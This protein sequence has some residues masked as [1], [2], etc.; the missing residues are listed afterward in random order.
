MNTEQLLSRTYKE[1]D[2]RTWTT[3]AVTSDGTVVIG[4]GATCDQAIS[5]ATR[6]LST[7]ESFLFKPPQEQLQKLLS[8]TKRGQLGSLAAERCIRLLAETILQD[9]SVKGLD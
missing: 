4:K 2:G 5:D 9:S 6:K 7:F 1:L 3:N 8:T